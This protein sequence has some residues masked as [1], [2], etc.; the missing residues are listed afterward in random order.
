MN[1]KHYILSAMNKHLH[2]SSVD[3]MSSLSGMTEANWWITLW[4][5][6]I[7]IKFALTSFNATRSDRVPPV[8]HFLFLNLDRL[9]DRHLFPLLYFFCLSHS[10]WGTSALLCNFSLGIWREVW[11]FNGSCPRH[12]LP[13]KGSSEY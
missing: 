5:I 10:F 9:F 11:H 4:L 7:E 1:T 3:E 13:E 12:A 8:A 2:K 6:E